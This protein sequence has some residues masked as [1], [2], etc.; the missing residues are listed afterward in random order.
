MAELLIA[1]GA[2]IQADFATAAFHFKPS[3][4]GINWRKK[5][6]NGWRQRPAQVGRASVH[7]AAAGTSWQGYSAQSSGRHKLAEFP[8][9]SRCGTPWRK[10]KEKWFVGLLVGGWLVVG[11]LVVCWRLVGW[12]FV[13]GWWLA[14]NTR[15]H[16]LHSNSPCCTSGTMHF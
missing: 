4:C 1:G 7:R 14:T 12:W 5:A 6:G 11:R 13:V 10:K 15:A 3:R 16:D 8:K 2:S 9:P